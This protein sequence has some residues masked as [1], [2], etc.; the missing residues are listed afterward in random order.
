VLLFLAWLAVAGQL[1]A[2][3]AGR[4]APYPSAQE[5]TPRGPLRRLVRAG[6][7]AIE[8]RRRSS[9]ERKAAQA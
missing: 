5:R 8:R 7:L 3:A 4:Y 9:S 1:I 2:L 6:L